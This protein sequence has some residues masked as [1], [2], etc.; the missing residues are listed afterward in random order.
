MVYRIKYSFNSPEYC[1]VYE[2]SGSAGMRNPDEK[3]T[4]D[5]WVR[6]NA[7]LEHERKSFIFDG[8]VVT[9]IESEMGE[10]QPRNLEHDGQKFTYKRTV[11]INISPPESV[12]LEIMNALYERGYKEVPNKLP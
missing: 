3:D 7:F 1:G 12:P 9:R 6:A 11:T 2:V 4:L 8:R 5:A 10:T